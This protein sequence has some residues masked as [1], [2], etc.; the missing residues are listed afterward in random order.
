MRVLRFRHL[1]LLSLLTACQPTRSPPS[2]AACQNAVDEPSTPAPAPLHTDGAFFKDQAG[3]VVLLRGVNVAGNAKVPPFRALRSAADLDPLPGWGLNTLR[4]LFTWE[5]FEP[6]PC[7]YDEDYLS[8]I[9]QQVSW[10]EARG[11]YVF[12]DFHQD[13]YSRFSLGGCGEGFPEWAVLSSLATHAPDNGPRCDGWGVKLTFDGPNLDV[14]RGFHRDT[15]GAR[16]RYLAMVGRVAA[17]LSKHANVIGYE[18][19]NEPWGQTWELHDLFEDVGAALRAQD[20][21]RML[22]VPAHALGLVAP[23]VS[24]ENIVHAPH[25][26]DNGVYLSKA[27]AKGGVGVAL[28][29]MRQVSVTWGSPMLLGEF[30]ANE[31]SK[32]EAAYL[33]AISTWLDAHFVSATQW[34]YTPG[35]DPVAKDGFDAEDYSIVDDHLALRSGLFVPRPYPQ[36]TAGLPV[37]FARSASGFTYS[38]NHDPTLGATEVFVLDGQQVVSQSGVPVDCVRAGSVL[39]CTGATAGVATITVSR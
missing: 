22:F 26:Y 31:G 37:T 32:D 3:R 1:A 14:W 39:S 19:I 18:L 27:W 23:R 35:W 17:R 4:L 21:N 30:G 5:A 11:L 8:S 34:N 15:E 7:A 24:F 2:F 29:P 16:T 9:E 33:E 10:A 38:W 25:Y 12:V 20:P 36:K 28:E 6:Q 13:G